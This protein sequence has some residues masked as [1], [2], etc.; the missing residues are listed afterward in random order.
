MQIAH[1]VANRGTCGRA[2]VGAVIARDGRVLTT[3]YNGPP[4]RLPHC[5]DPGGCGILPSDGCSRAVHAEANAIAY[6]ARHGIATE[7]CTLYSTHLPCLKC[8]ELI[9]NAGIVAVYYRTDYRIRDGATLLY[10]AG[11]DIVVL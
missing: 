7:G 11:V 10:Q 6:A 3:G 2:Q 8:A 1:I 5:T 4:S 9:I